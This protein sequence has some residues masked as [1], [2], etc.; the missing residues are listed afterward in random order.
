MSGGQPWMQTD[1]NR[2]RGKM[3]A[4]AQWVRAFATHAEDWMFES[5]SRQT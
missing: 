5:L 2:S 1:G 4:V 3:A